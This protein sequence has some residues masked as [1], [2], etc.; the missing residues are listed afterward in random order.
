MAGLGRLRFSM[1]S[2]GLA[3]NGFGPES[4]MREW[5]AGLFNCAAEEVRPNFLSE[6][7]GF[8]EAAFDV[9]VPE[10]EEGKL[11]RAQLIR[12]CRK[13]WYEP[14][15]GEEYGQFRDSV[16]PSILFAADKVQL[17]QLEGAKAYVLD[18]ASLSAEQSEQLGDLSR[19]LGGLAEGAA[20]DRAASTRS[21]EALKDA[22]AQG[23]D[24]LA[25]TLDE[26]RTNQQELQKVVGQQSEFLDEAA[27]RATAGEATTAA[28]MQTTHTVAGALG[29]LMQ[30]S[31][32][33][34]AEVSGHLQQQNH[35]LHQLYLGGTCG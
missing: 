22:H 21:T 5:L 29:F 26:L 6:D 31:T 18:A 32:A 12:A 13:G 28:A 9:A 11:V 4:A 35:T 10:T 23:M 25:A 33:Q 30:Q 20:K 14:E 1:L 15:L 19:M 8:K 24:K 27:R 7:K 3:R 34:W 17:A 2:P 16:A